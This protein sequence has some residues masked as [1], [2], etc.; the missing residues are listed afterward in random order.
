MSLTEISKHGGKFLAAEKLFPRPH[1]GDP[2]KI[3]FGTIYNKTD[4]SERKKKLLA[5]QIN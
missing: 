4:I 5:Y 3:L 1:V 2:V